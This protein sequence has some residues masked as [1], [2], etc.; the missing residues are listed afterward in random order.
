MLTVRA[1]LM[2]RRHKDD[3]ADDAG[4]DDAD[5]LSGE[6]EEEK[7]SDRLASNDEFDEPAAQSAVAVP[8]VQVSAPVPGQASEAMS[9]SPCWT[10]LRQG[11]PFDTEAVSVRQIVTVCIDPAST[12]NLIDFEL[13][14]ARHMLLCQ[15]M[16]Q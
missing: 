16:H 8:P 2:L 9:S 12:A 13:P 14:G 11:R 15:T 10:V 4:I 7:E 5:T 1:A 3:G 6:D